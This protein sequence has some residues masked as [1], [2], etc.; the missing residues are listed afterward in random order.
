MCLCCTYEH[1]NPTDFLYGPR[2][3]TW[4][5]MLWFLPSPSFSPWLLAFLPE[6]LLWVCFLP[7]IILWMISGTLWR[8]RWES[9]EVCLQLAHEFLKMI[10]Q[11][12][13]DISECIVPWLKIAS[14][15]SVCCIE[16]PVRENQ[17]MDLNRGQTIFSSKGQVADGLQGGRGVRCGKD[18]HRSKPSVVWEHESN[19]LDLYTLENTERLAIFTSGSEVKDKWI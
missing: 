6:S 12:L 15:P 3:C 8:D 14:F 16:T 4:H 17:V 5:P 10:L 2:S 9:H 7:G 18:A 19:R 11:I 13:F 1:L